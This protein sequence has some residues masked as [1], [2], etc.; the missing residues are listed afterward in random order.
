MLLER[1]D[2][3][4]EGDFPLGPLMVR[5]SV[6]RLDAAD[7]TE[8][9][10]QPQVMRVLVALA[11]QPGEVVTRDALI[12]TCWGGGIVT[13][14]SLGRCIS[15]LRATFREAGAEALSI[16]PIS[17]SGYRLLAPAAPPPES[18]AIPDMP[19]EPAAVVPPFPMPAPAP[20]ATPGAP[21]VWGRSL[22]RAALA[23]VALLALGAAG[24]GIVLRGDPGAWE[25][26]GVRLLTMGNEAEYAP[27]L[28][29]DGT[30]LL[31]ARL[32]EDGEGQDLF[33]RPLAGGPDRRLTDAPGLDEAAA[34]SPDGTEIAFVRGSANAP[35]QCRILVLRL[36]QGPERD[37]GP[38]RDLQFT[39]M[40]WSGDGR[41]LILTDR[42]SRLG[43]G[44]QAL[45]L[46]DGTRRPLTDPTATALGDLLPT[47]S[48][49]GT[50]LAFARRFAP[51]AF[52]VMVLELATG[53][54]RR[55]TEDLSRIQGLAWA[56]DGQGLFATS[57]RGGDTG[58]WWIPL[59]G[60]APRRLL[61]GLRSLGSVS[62][63]AA[64]PLLV[65]ESRV[66]R[67]S[68]LELDADTGAPRQTDAGFGA[69]RQPAFAP[70]GRLAFVSE[71]SGTAE[72][73]LREADGA[74]RPLTQ[75]GSSYLVDPRWSADGRRIVFAASIEGTVDVYLLSLEDGQV[76]RLTADAQVKW[77][78]AFAAGGQA[79]HYSGGG[80]GATALR[81]VPL[82]AEG[83]P[84]GPPV[85]GPEAAGV[86]PGPGGDLY[87]LSR[88]RRSVLRRPAGGGPDETLFD[89]GGTAI[90]DWDVAA[91][92]IAL[93]LR[94]PDQPELARV[95]VLDAAT[96]RFTPFDG[97]APVSSPGGVALSPDGRTVVAVQA[98]LP[99]IRLHAVTL[100]PR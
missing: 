16:E 10:L 89:A 100:K 47:V 51:G 62:A 75:L 27:A 54:V 86:L 48:P 42:T 4:R 6:H 26:D 8:L 58:V 94:L 50:R 3:A 88:D 39:T 80:V 45:S 84:A 83:R 21:P 49:D 12:R 78:P 87:L 34:W 67:S 90:E 59:D 79:V 31:F 91:G 77:E 92:R 20:G 7:G 85:P 14:E 70:D 22:R 43:G 53:E 65:V 55:L 73:W 33:L 44:L 71:R 52:D 18:P 97:V 56:P 24:A 81:S 64:E 19:E 29:P 28:S 69:D 11:R 66:E 96:G 57:R 37:L 98:H 68:L 95:G 5:P 63:A 13:D 17:K 60:G 74:V 76:R 25:A 35:E 46:A 61:P 2:L 38:C 93:L 40:A 23:G 36:P 15:R 9:R 41:E 30:R 72:L 1:I 99:D 32:A 82:D